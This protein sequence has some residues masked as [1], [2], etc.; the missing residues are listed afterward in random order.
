MILLAH[1]HTPPT[2]CSSSCTVVAPCWMD[3]AH[4]KELS[5]AD[6]VYEEA[7]TGKVRAVTGADPPLITECRQHALKRRISL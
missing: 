4:S 3:N 7:L 1:T 2:T 5:Q 6:L